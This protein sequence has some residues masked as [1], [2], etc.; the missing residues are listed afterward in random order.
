MKVKSNGS[1][2]TQKFSL[3]NNGLIATV[4]SSTYGLFTYD[5]NMWTL[6][7][8]ETYPTDFTVKDDEIIFCAN[9]DVIKYDANS[10]LLLSENII[11]S[12]SKPIVSSNGDVFSVYNTKL[13]RTTDEGENWEV[14][15]DSANSVLVVNGDTLYSVSNNGI[16]RSDNNG[17]NWNI[18]NSGIPSTYAQKL[19]TVGLANGKVYA[20][21]NGTRARMHLPPVWEQGGVYVSSDNGE[22]WSSL[23]T[24]LPQEG[25]IY[26]PVYQ[27]TSDGSVVLLNTI[28]GRFS[29]VNNSWVNIGSG[30]PANTYLSSL[31]IFKDDV[32]FLTNN[33]LFISHDKG[34]T[35]EDFNNGLSGLTNYLTI[36]FTYQDELYVF[37]TDNNIVYKFENDQWNVVNFTLPENVRLTSAQSVGDIIYAGTY[38]NGIWKYDPTPTNVDEVILPEKFSLSQNYP[39]PFNPNTTISFNIA[40][41]SYVKLI[42]YDI[43]G[44]EVATLVNENRNAGENIVNFNASSLSSGVYLYRLQA[45]NF[46]E[47]KKMLLMK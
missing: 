1:T 6:L 26:S 35:K 37:S 23:N 2:F 32:I 10:N 5:G 18:F 47:T 33:G 14:L 28:A 21:V 38:D 9:G 20:G 42:V 39:N 15:K 45:G 19:S 22:N 25:G 31:M 17:E 11:A 27:I 43:L 44:N 34:I 36:L 24:G 41:N 12:T 13:Y 8:D 46:I 29:L 7:Y 30:F 4:S 3:Y 40:E 16:I